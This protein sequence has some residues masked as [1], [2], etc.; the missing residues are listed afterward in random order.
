MKILITGA[1]NG[2][3]LHLCNSL[4][5]NGHH[6]LAISKNIYNLEKIKN[7]N[8][9]YYQVDIRN[10]NEIQFAINDISEFYNNIDVL[11]NNAAIYLKADLLESTIEQIEQ[12]IDTNIKGTI[13]I[14]KFAL[15]RLLPESGKIIMINSVAGTHGIQ[16]ESIYSASKFA[17]NGFSE[18]LQIELKN[19]KISITN[20]YPGGINT[21][22][23]NQN[24]LYSGNI[25]D[26]LDKDDIYS[27]INLIINLPPSK[28]LK[29]LTIYPASE[30]H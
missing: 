5:D 25:S 29:N 14:T 30:N 24:N 17:L 13:F 6:I 19:K 18:S 26:L 4:L 3:G 16:N 7:P 15:E 27:L 11:I 21:T 23:W 8:L 9:R 12:V 20:I 28:I 2:L 1:N 22:L 10:Y